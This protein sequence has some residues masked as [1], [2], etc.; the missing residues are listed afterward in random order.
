MTPIQQRVLGLVGNGPA[1]FL[2]IL[3]AFEPLGIKRT[4]TG[5]AVIN[6]LNDR[7]LFMVE[8][9]KLVVSI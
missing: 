2:E 7:K 1:T 3:A 5:R 8:D 6:L 4:D 9:S